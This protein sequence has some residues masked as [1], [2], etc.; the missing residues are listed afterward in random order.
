MTRFKPS[1]ASVILMIIAGVVL[2]LFVAVA[3]PLW[4]RSQRD[5]EPQ[6][7]S[8]LAPDDE[9]RNATKI[10]Y[11]ATAE[12]VPTGGVEVQGIKPLTEGEIS[13]TPEPDGL[14]PI[15]D[16]VPAGDGAIIERQPPFPGSMYR[17]TNAWYVDAADGSQRTFVWA[18]ARVLDD[19]TLAGLVIVQEYA[20]DNLSESVTSEYDAP[21]GTG[22]LT[23]TGAEGH[24]VALSSEEGRQLHYDAAVRS[25]TD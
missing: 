20:A 11:S 9:A 14:L 25:F 22:L 6:L 13:I 4:I 23:I 10:A 19:G 1:A 2:F 17:I 18:G 16:A 15:A 3:L 21:S 5:V 7:E 8:T 24:V 12:F